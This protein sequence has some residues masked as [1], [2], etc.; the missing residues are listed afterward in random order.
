MKS[1]IVGKRRANPVITCSNARDTGPIREAC[2][3][4]AT[5]V[6]ECPA[7]EGCTLLNYSDAEDLVE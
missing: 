2:T 6:I 7:K 4:T 3:Q 1:L 5:S